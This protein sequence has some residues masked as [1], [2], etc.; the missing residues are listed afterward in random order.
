MHMGRANKCGALR[1]GD[2]DMQTD[3]KKVAG[4]WPPSGVG[5]VAGEWGQR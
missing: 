1:K 5:P 3:E 4:A 2:A